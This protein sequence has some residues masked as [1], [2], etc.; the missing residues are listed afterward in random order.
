VTS[1]NIGFKMTTHEADLGSSNRSEIG[2]RPM[3]RRNGASEGGQ[4]LLGL[5][6]SLPEGVEGF[7]SRIRKDDLL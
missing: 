2:G 6:P 5:T 3:K 7:S 1:D 4:D